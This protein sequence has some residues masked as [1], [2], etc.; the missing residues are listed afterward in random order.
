[1]VLNDLTPQIMNLIDQ[2]GSNGVNNNTTTQIAL[3]K[4]PL[5]VND[6]YQDLID[7]EKVRKTFLIEHEHDGTENLYVKYDMPEDFNGIDFIVNQD[8]NYNYNK[9]AMYKAEGN[10]LYVPNN[11]KGTL[12]VVY[13]PE[14]SIITALTDTLL[15]KKSTASIIFVIIF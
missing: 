5:F 2:V 1:M 6:I 9:V 15:I 11:F 3:K 14:P 4:I 7:V 8:S 10:S 12:K 13:K